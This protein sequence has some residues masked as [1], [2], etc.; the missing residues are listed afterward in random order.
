KA[1]PPELVAVLGDSRWKHWNVVCDVAF[2]PNGKVLAS[3]GEDG[4]VRL[5]DLATGKELKHSLDHDA[6]VTTV[7]FAPSGKLL[8]TGSAN[9]IVRMLDPA[10]LVE[11]R[12]FTG[13]TAGIT[14]VCF[15]PDGRL[16]ASSSHDKTAIVWNV[17]TG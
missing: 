16:L 12:R 14:A 1:T 8:A 2:H 7:A 4:F 6:S 15:S 5:W 17:A 3:A 9:H 13:H 11:R 10:T